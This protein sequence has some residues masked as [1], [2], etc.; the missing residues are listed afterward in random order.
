MG[1]EMCIRDSPLTELPNRRYLINRIEAALADAKRREEP[2][3]L[4]L[5]DLDHFKPINDQYGHDAG[6][7]MLHSIGQRL[8]DNVRANDMVA[9]L[10]GD[11]FA[12]LITGADAEQHARDVA[13]RLLETLAKPV[14]YGASQLTVTI[15]IGVALYPRHGQQFANLYKA[16]D[17]ALYQAKQ[18]GRSG[19]L[20]HEAEAA[21]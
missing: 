4:L 2:L 3:A 13:M 18:Q 15:S 14:L 21:C 17:E 7:L 6:D 11:E 12:V 5:L 1:S 9:R 20:V 10:G 16:A 8:H 19:F